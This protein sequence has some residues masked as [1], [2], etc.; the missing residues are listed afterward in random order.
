MR[1]LLPLAVRISVVFM[2]PNASGL[3]ASADSAPYFARGVGAHAELV[4]RERDEPLHAVAAVDVEQLAQRTQAVRRIGIARM[5]RIV[6]EPPHV[7]VAVPAVELQFAQVVDIGP[8]DMDDLA[9]QPLARDV[10]RRHLEEVVTAVLERTMQWRRVRSA[11]STSAQ[12]SATVSAA[13]TSTATCLP[14]SMA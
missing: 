7:D 4:G 6:F 12:Q 10:E 1:M 2:S 13:G 11:A 3:S 5:Q 14:R 9:E 8:L